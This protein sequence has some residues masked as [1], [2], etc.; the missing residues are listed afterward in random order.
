MHWSVYAGWMQIR[1]IMHGF[2]HIRP[3][4]DDIGN[5]VNVFYN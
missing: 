1:D 4:F 5:K 3:D 2:H